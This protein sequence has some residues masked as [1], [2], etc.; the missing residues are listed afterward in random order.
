MTSDT[1]VT[2]PS[3]AVI[4]I[5]A[6]AIIVVMA[7]AGVFGA[8]AYGTH[9]PQLAFGGAFCLVVATG[10]VWL[11]VWD[12]RRMIAAAVAEHKADAEHWYSEVNRR[13]P[14]RVKRVI[15]EN[16]VS[17]ANQLAELNREMGHLA[18]KALQ[19]QADLNGLMDGMGEDFAEVL[20]DR[21]RLRKR[22][23]LV[24]EIRAVA[25]REQEEPA[26]AW[27]ARP[28]DLADH[29]TPQEFAPPIERAKAA[30]HGL[31]IL[32][33]ELGAAGGSQ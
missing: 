24:D 11:L 10:A 23:A 19:A 31:R 30:D 8:A 16:V 26:R 5:E 17:A 27:P 13:P 2:A 33:S 4:V 21:D 32:E 15:P 22:A 1:E 20:A 7:L 9:D 29:R 12:V 28:L 18:A 3:T 14:V 25:T 6:A